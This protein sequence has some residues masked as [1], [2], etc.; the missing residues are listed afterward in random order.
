MN[1]KSMVAAVF[2][3]GLYFGSTWFFFGSSHP[4]E[5][6]IVRQKDH[7]IAVAERHHREDVESWQDFARKAFP[8]RD[9]DRFANNVEEYSNASGRVEN[10]R[11]SVVLGL[12]A[13]VGELTPAQCAW[14]AITWD[15]PV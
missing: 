8:A 14:Q 10:I 1:L 15:S 2:V 13:K 7:H 11:R 9:Y 6:L 3:I 4:C 5:I 12:R